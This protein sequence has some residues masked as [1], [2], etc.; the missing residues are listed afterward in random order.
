MKPNVEVDLPGIYCDKKGEEQFAVK[1]CNVEVIL[2]SH[3][4]LYS[5]TRLMEEGHLVKDNKKDG[6]TAQKG[7]RVIKFNIIVK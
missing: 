1:L 3:Y 4:N 2:E 6:I 7:G 5:T